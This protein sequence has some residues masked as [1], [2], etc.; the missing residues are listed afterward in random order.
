M[1]DL[2]IGRY[3]LRA[4]IAKGG[5][6]TVWRAYDRHLQRDVAVKLL[7]PWIADDEELRRRFAQEAKVLAPLEHEHIVRLY[8]YGENGETPFLVMEYVDGASLGDVARG[9]GWTWGEVSELARPIASALAYAH[10]RGIV[11]RDLTPGNILIER[12]TGRVVVSDFGLARIARSATSVVTRG[13]L[14]GT[15]EYWSPEQARGVE[16]QTASDLYALGCLLFWLLVGRTPFEG[17]DRLAVGLRR[18]HEAAPAVS[19]SVPGASSDAAETIDALLAVD[20][21]DRPTAA[22]LLDRLGVSRSSIADAAAVAADALTRE[23]AVFPPQPV[24]AVLEAPSR[25]AARRRRRGRR[26]MA[27]VL[28]IAA[29]GALA[30]VGATI[31]N[32][33]RVVDV[34]RVT[35]MTV[36]QARSATAA[37]AHVDIADAPLVVGGRVYSESVPEGRILTQTPVADGQVERASFDLVVR[38]S[39]GTAFAEVP[40]VEGAEQQAA[41]EALRAIGFAVR[42]RSEE[43]WEIPEGRVIASDVPAGDD[44]R[45][46][47]PIGITVSSGPPRAPV[48]D[49]RGAAV[50]D[51][52][53]RLDGSFE[54]DVVAE[55]A[56][57]VEPGTVLRQAPAPGGRAVLG[58][59]VTLTVARA[60]EWSAT[61]SESGTGDYESEPVEVTVPQGDWRIVVDLDPRYLIFGSGSAT[62]LW[63]GTGSGQIGLDQ[64]GSESVAPLSGAGT[65]TVRVRPIGSV[66]W[67]L[68]IEQLG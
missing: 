48:P 59:T 22:E 15:P 58:S 16:S 20:P 23:T 39:R 25:H 14:L 4:R 47:G 34:P 56:E 42:A 37:A 66:S 12:S 50:D 33:D 31:A 13:M 6:G 55:G 21:A 46:P 44:A 54:S 49:V 8:D 2:L 68:R 36:P 17:D 67:T 10:A 9:R 3:E 65:Y 19:T 41:T 32:A 24:T 26:M 29:A 7:H 61:W 28:G 18:A 35:G 51:A 45:R 63:A 52:I 57:G 53:S 27:V 5:M 62:V 38:V 30:F 1:T 11:H 40:D 43:S 60:P 64:V